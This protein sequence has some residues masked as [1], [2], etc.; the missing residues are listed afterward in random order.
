[1]PLSSL[2]KRPRYRSDRIAGGKL[3][4]QIR[5][6]CS[7][8]GR[9]IQVPC[10]D[11]AE[12][13][14]RV[15]AYPDTL[16]LSSLGSVT[17]RVQS[18]DPNL[19]AT[20]RLRN[21]SF[22]RFGAWRVVDSSTDPAGTADGLFAYSPLATTDFSANANYDPLRVDAE[23][24][25]RTVAIDGDGKLYDGSYL[26]TVDW[27][28]AGSSANS[29]PTAVISSLSGFT[30]GGVGVSQ[31]G[32]SHTFSGSAVNETPPSRRPD[33]SICPRS[34]RTANRLSRA[35]FARRFKPV[36]WVHGMANFPGMFGCAGVM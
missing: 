27:N 5:A 3:R 33:A 29:A 2:S 20:I 18:D 12:W 35:G 11:H 34:L 21:T 25:G 10:A 19:R 6:E 31:I 7:L 16:P 4:G 15:V 28:P 36:K 32:F 9:P 17:N 26:L 23:Y 24:A 13:P 30:I 14:R 1:M 8:D 22:A